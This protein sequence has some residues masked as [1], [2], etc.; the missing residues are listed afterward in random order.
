MLNPTAVER[1]QITAHDDR[2]LTPG[3]RAVELTDLSIRW[4]NPSSIWTPMRVGGC[5]ALYALV[6]KAYV[7]RG[8]RDTCPRARFAQCRRG[9]RASRREYLRRTRGHVARQHR[10]RELVASCSRERGGSHATPIRVGVEWHRSPET[11]FVKPGNERPSNPRFTVAYSSH[12]D[13]FVQTIVIGFSSP[14]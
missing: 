13:H 2:L 9:G 5:Q 14:S 8:H 7:D 10:R 11:V 12:R 1:I 6:L 3:R 4:R